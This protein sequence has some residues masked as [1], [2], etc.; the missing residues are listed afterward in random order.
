LRP[1]LRP[2]A[3]QLELL[4]TIPGIS[5]RTA[6][7]V[8][9][10]VGPDLTRFG[11]A[12]QLASW[13]GLCPGN[14]ESAGR[15]HGGTTRKGSPWLRSALVVSAAS[16]GRT[17][18]Y[19][20]A[21]FRRLTAR[22]GLMRAKVAVAHSLLVIIRAMLVRDEPFR[23]LGVNY[24]DERDRQQVERRLTRRLEALGFAVVP[25]PTTT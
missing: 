18:T 20:G 25:A 3:H 15:R 1:A 9:A 21:Q 4:T 11:S 23:D 14:H 22:R 12:R 24:F 17:Q 8:L 13:A 7:I 16:A 5:R 2:F 19:L 6:E 10:E